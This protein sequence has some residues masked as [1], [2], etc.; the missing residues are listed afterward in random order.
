[1]YLTNAEDAA[2]LHLRSH[3]KAVWA[4]IFQPSP[5]KWGTSKQSRCN[6]SPA[7]RKRN[8][9]TK[10]KSKSFQRELNCWVTEGFH[11]RTDF[12]SNAERIFL[13]H[14]PGPCRERRGVTGIQKTVHFH[15]LV[16]CDNLHLSESCQLVTTF[17]PN[18]NWSGE[19][20]WAE[21]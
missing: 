4:A 7:C 21:T 5:T 10:N 3:K 19:S 2:L 13:S 9:R 1:M 16:F 11:H 14:H 20:H 18:I 12:I 15:C 8:G 17:Y 6:K